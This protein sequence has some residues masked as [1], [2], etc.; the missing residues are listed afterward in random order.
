MSYEW[1]VRRKSA[2]HAHLNTEMGTDREFW[3]VTM[4][5]ATRRIP[6][7]IT[8]IL[9]PVLSKMEI[10]PTRGRL[11]EMNMDFRSTFHIGVSFNVISNSTAPLF[12]IVQLVIIGI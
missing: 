4:K 8:K 12:R 10:G 5:T 1:L 2:R 7:L 3:S 9:S 11:S 6:L